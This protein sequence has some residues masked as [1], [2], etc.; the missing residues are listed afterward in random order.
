MK[1]IVIDADACPKNVLKII[2]HLTQ[3]YQ[4]EMVTVASFHHHITDSPN[5][6]IT[7]DESQAADLQIFKVCEKNDIVVTQDGGLAALVLSKGCYALS[8]QGYLYE[9]EKID[10]LLEERNI[11][12]K[13]FRQGGKYKG[14]PSARTKK[15]D[16]RF[17]KTLQGL[18]ERIENK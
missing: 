10:F 15:D 2:G 8:P 5:H 7:S 4:W 16:Q 1:N 12:A 13:H 17:E 9:E 3:K 18:M 14:G 6:I 11:K